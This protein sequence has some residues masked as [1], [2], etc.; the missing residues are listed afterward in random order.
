MVSLKASR[1][2]IMALQV[3]EMERVAPHRKLINLE[4]V[5]FLDS[6]APL[7]LPS[8]VEKS[9]SLILKKQR[10]ESLLSDRHTSL[11]K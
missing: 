5:D 8:K 4:I 11:K 7:N 9:F 6:L 3:V 2:L 10:G 1:I